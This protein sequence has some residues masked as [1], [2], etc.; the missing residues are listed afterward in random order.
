VLSSS[1]HFVKNLPSRIL[2]RLFRLM[3]RMNRRYSLNGDAPFFD[4]DRF[5]WTAQV[6]A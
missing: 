6:A 1:A 5:P 2:Y 4:P 3:E